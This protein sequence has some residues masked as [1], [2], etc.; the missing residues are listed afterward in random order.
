MGS[1][2]SKN[3]T[4]KRISIAPTKPLIDNAAGSGSGEDQQKLDARLPYSGFRDFFTLKNYWKTVRRNEK[5]CA[6]R[7][8][9]EYGVL[10]CYLGLWG[11]TRGQEEE[12]SNNSTAPI[13]ST[14]YFRYFKASPD[15]VAKYGKLKSFTLPNS[16]DKCTDSH[17]EAVA[18]SYLKLFDE[19]IGAIEETPADASS[20]C[21]RLQQIGRMHRT[22][23]SGMKP[24]DFQQM[25]T[26]FLHMVEEA[27]QDR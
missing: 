20:A 13:S 2:A 21:Q 14:H 10:G 19:V 23:V 16:V 5:G 9:Y 24:D 12:I 27:L 11:I 15:N 3:K 26:P 6:M 22:K 8:L 18:M 17:F 1:G 25:E 4:A 7:L